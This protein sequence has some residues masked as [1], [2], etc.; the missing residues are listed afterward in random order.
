MRG[1]TP[2]DGAAAAG[3]GEEGEA[4]QD[5]SSS[6]RR[7]RGG[8]KWGKEEPFLPLTGV[9]LSEWQ[10]A[11]YACSCIHHC[12]RVSCCV[13]TS[14]RWHR[15]YYGVKDEFPESQLMVRA[16]AALSIYLVS[17][18]V[19][20][21]LFNCKDGLRRVLLASLPASH[22]PARVAHT[23][24]TFPSPDHQHRRG[25]AQEARPAQH[26]LPLPPQPRGAPRRLSGATAAL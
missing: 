11:K 8:K 26:R 3:E 4:A 12:R 17:D 5:S 16:E 23:S 2:A 10:A 13:L 9:M 24:I 19:K 21:I 25:S 14:R 1:D 6:T 15:E 20:D 18:G 22:S 7:S